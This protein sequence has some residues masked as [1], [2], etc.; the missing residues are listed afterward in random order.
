MQICKCD[1]DAAKKSPFASPECSEF[2]PPRIFLEV[3]ADQ[4]KVEE[5]DCPLELIGTTEKC[6]FTLTSPKPDPTSQLSQ[7]TLS[8]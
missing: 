4:H 6:T 5:L 8:D 1:V 2:Y 7:G 3:A